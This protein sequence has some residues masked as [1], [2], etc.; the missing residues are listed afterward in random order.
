MPTPSSSPPRSS[1][2]PPGQR[3]LEALVQSP[4]KQLFVSLRYT[5]ELAPLAEGL[6]FGGIRGSAPDLEEVRFQTVDHEVIK[7]LGSHL[8]AQGALASIT[9]LNISYA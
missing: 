2:S 5:A 9:T 6:L 7:H 8:F 3:L 1:S 4:S